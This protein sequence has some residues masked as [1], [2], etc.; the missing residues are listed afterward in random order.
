M[1]SLVCPNAKQ[2]FSRSIKL[3]LRRGLASVSKLFRVVLGDF[4]VV[5]DDLEGKQHIQR[6]LT[7][8]TVLALLLQMVPLGLPAP[9]EVVTPLLDEAP[10][11]LDA[12]VPIAEEVTA[13][14][15]AL[16]ASFS[17]PPPLAYAAPVSP[18]GYITIT[19]SYPAT[20]YQQ[21]D[22]DNNQVEIDFTYEMTI[23]NQTGNS[24]PPFSMR[25]TT[26]LPTGIPN[27]EKSGGGTG[28]NWLLNATGDSPVRFINE[29]D[30]P[31]GSS[32]VG[33]Y[34][35]YILQAVPDRTVVT[36]TQTFF[37][38]N[39]SQYTETHTY[40]TKVRAPAYG[41]SITP[42]QGA[43]VCAG[44][45]VTYTITVS[46]AGGAPMNA[47]NPFS[48][49]A[50]LPGNV[51]AYSTDGGISQGNWVS[52]TYPALTLVGAAVS[53]TLVVS[54]TGVWNNGD[55]IVIKATALANAE[56]TPTVSTS[57]TVTVDRLTAEFT[58]TPGLTVSV[59][60]V[61][62]FT[63]TYTDPIDTTHA[64][65]F[66]DGVTTTPTGPT[67]VVT[68]TYSSV[69]TYVVTQTVSNSCPG[70]VFTQTIYV[71]QPELH[72]LK[73]DTPDPV[74]AGQ[75]LTYTIYYS[76]TS[77]VVAKDVVITD[78]LPANIITGTAT[79]PPDGGTIGPGNVITWDVG[80]L[81][82]GEL[83]S[84]TL[85][86]DVDS[87]LDNGTVLTNAAGITCSVGV[88]T[89]TGPVTTTVVSTPTLHIVK[90]DDPDP[91]NAGD[92]LTYT[93]VYS[94]SGNMTA[95]GV[96]IT[97]TFDGNVSFDGSNPAPS[98]GSGSYWGW[99]TEAL[100]PSD[101]YI[102]VITAT[103]DSP[104]PDSTVLTNTADITCSEGVSDTTGPVNTIVWSADVAITKAVTPITSLR[105][106]D[107]LTYTLTFAN[108][109]HT[110]ATGVV[111]TDIY[112]PI[113]LTNV[114]STSSG[115]IV[116]P[117]AAAPPYTWE[118]QDLSYGQGGVITIT[119]QVTSAQTG[120]WTA[121]L[122]NTAYIT[123]A[124]PDGDGA[125]DTNEVFSVLTGGYVYYYLPIVVKNWDGALD[126]GL[127]GLW[128]P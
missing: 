84:N 29:G 55:S 97:D 48:V 8:A 99:Y 100:S 3:C 62:T 61:V 72:I 80:T 52:W 20:T 69:D 19:K 82:A 101:N 15:D 89:K 92:M 27:W 11:P 22:I 66:G 63:D 14:F 112:Q 18:A 41:V 12:L 42:S 17:S 107:W 116:T 74:P 53:K 21:W 13:P 9:S 111:I 109:G 108:Q 104:L 51:I 47:V 122:T 79:P 32:Y 26:T 90:T 25:V 57:N 88:Y 73:L 78:T 120:A 106:G 16:A 5:L 95:S 59:S 110:T 98:G 39:G 60:S 37:M 102:I 2:S 125:N 1:R 128:E 38:Y 83:L 34:T 31:T 49:T 94:N 121:I 113:S 93:I 115:A 71:I 127:S 44:D 114:I 36:D 64:W 126:S 103:V 81:D 76:N 6:I 10:P 67:S 85:V 4:M 24:I 28:S 50:E 124:Q 96:W 77:Q 65:E 54:P 56:V 105:S 118:V 123:T 35:L 46:N 70:D 117:T 58:T 75:Q 33:N 30:V 87:P 68:H 86:V 43:T 119:A 23:T 40:A 45:L 7:L 91:V